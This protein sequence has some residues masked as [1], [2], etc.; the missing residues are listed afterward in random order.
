M[1]DAEAFVW[2]FIGWTDGDTLYVSYESVQLH[3]LEW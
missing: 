1:G 2:K 3:Y